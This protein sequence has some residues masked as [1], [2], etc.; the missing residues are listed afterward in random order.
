MIAQALPQLVEDLD[1]VTAPVAG[2]LHWGW[3]MA[4]VV[5]LLALLI[6]LYLTFRQR[7]AQT[8]GAGQQ[9][10]IDPGLLAS[11]RL[12]LLRKSLPAMTQREAAIELA[13]ILR[14]Y[15]ASRFAIRAPYQTTGE[16]IRNLGL[17]HHF[18]ADRS[19]A[20]TDL[21]STS[22]LVK[23]ATGVLNEG[24][25]EQWIEYVA[26][27]VRNTEPPTPATEAGPV[28]EKNRG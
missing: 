24:A 28:K 22:D 3:I 19:Q 8:A 25:L 5:A 11:E 7:A 20:V 15:I 10:E 14:D 26:D 27:F 4:A 12:K 1:L 21:L 13:S 18:P 2:A 17:A 6:P 23:F 16:F 9:P